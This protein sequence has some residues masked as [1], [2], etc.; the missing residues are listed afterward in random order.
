MGDELVV[1]PHRTK[2]RE[3]LVSLPRRKEVDPKTGLQHP[4]AVVIDLNWGKGIAGCHICAR[5]IPKGTTRLKLDVRLAV[6]VDGR[7]TETYYLHPGCITD[8]IKPEV[9]RMGRDCFDCG[10]VPLAKDGREVFHP[11]RCFTVSKFVTAPLCVTCI[12]KPRW[13]ICDICT[14]VYP[15]FMVSVVVDDRATDSRPAV[16]AA[17]SFTAFDVPPNIYGAQRVCE[18]CTVRY[19]IRT[20]KEA[21]DA[22]AE[23]EKLRKEILEHGFFEAGE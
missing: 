16:A 17:S 23:F 6:P 7:D 20:A 1:E 18:S 12:E 11:H 13:D 22:A 9:I 21:H 8:R 15:R 10:A 14:I 5:P 2:R 19:N 3:P 4:P